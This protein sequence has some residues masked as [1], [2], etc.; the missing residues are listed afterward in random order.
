MLWEAL[1][2]NNEASHIVLVRQMLSTFII[3]TYIRSPFES[4]LVH[5]TAVLRFNS[6]TRQL[7]TAKNYSYLVAG[8]VYCVQVI[9]VKHL[10][11]PAQREQQGL[12]ERNHYLNLRKR[13]LADKS[14]SPTSQLLSLLA[15]GKF[16]SINTSNAGNAF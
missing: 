11:P 4:G 5:F 15:Y 14:F 13:F 7:H 12:V 6:E 9:S 2:S 16:I 8:M 3:T 10:L 1:D